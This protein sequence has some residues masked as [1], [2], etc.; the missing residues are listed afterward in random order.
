MPFRQIARG[1]STRV[2]RKPVPIA[3]NRERS[4]LRASCAWTSHLRRPEAGEQAR[5]VRTKS[6][7]GGAHVGTPQ[8]VL[9]VLALAMLGVI[10]VASASLPIAAMR[11]ESPSYLL[12]KHLIALAVGLLVFWVCWRVDYRVFLK[13]DHIFLLGA[14]GLTALTLVP[15]LATRG[16]WLRLPGPFQ[17]QPTEFLKLALII[18]FA[19]MIERKGD[20]L[21]EFSEGVLPPLLITTLAALMALKQSDFAMALIFFLIVFCM[22]FIGRARLAHLFGIALAAVPALAL[23]LISAPYRFGRLLAFL[24]PFAYSTTEGYQLVQSLTAIGSG[25]VFGRGLGG[26]REK[27]LFLPEPYNDFIFSIVGEELGLIGGLLVIGLFAYLTWVGYTI[28]TRTPDRFGGLLAAGITLTLA[29][30]ACINLGVTTGILPVT[31][32]TLPF[33]SYGG[34]SL[35]VSFAMTGI[36]CN[37]SRKGLYENT[38]LW[39]R[40]RGTSL[41]RPRSV[42]RVAAR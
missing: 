41:P 22:L 19:A 15:G 30:Q 18:S 39:G 23:V 25:G 13:I 32:V 21:Q 1:T 12:T 20:R 38:R 27:L 31:G 3:Y 17:L 35:I 28:A 6:G 42:G 11:Y 37:I 33:I 26:S 4:R 2:L 14:F 7:K 29:A 9:V 24:D 8:L 5:L 16:S 36:L 34:S 40:D 10:M